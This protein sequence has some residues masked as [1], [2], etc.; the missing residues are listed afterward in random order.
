M[1][2]YTGYT[3]DKKSRGNRG[4]LKYFCLF[5]LQYDPRLLPCEYNWVRINRRRVSRYVL[6]VK[7]T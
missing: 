5:I 1:I 2:N 3:R 4:Q 7:Q 6:R